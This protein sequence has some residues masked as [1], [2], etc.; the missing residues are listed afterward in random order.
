MGHGIFQVLS[1]GGEFHLITDHAPLLWLCKTK[2]DNAQIT[3]WALT[4]QLFK[5]SI[6]CRPRATNKVT[7]FL[8][9]YE[10][11]PTQEEEPGIRHQRDVEGLIRDNG[12]MKMPQDNLIGG[13]YGTET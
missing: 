13:M 4:L 9:R 7:D 1:D 11:T 10:E 8:S 5:F 2:T 3:R 12:K 6:G